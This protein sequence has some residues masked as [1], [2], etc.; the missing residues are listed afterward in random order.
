MTVRLSFIP[1]DAEWIAAA[2]RKQA[3]DVVEADRNMAAR[4]IALGYRFKKAAKEVGPCQ[5]S[6]RDAQF[7]ASSLRANSEHLEHLA[8]G[9][10]RCGRITDS[11]LTFQQSARSRRLA[12]EIEALLTWKAGGHVEL[13][14][15]DVARLMVGGRQ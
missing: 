9:Y 6:E 11:R 3:E 1:A 7:A 14:P 5:M 15:A 4:A 12:M 10:R 8:V 2:L 13:N